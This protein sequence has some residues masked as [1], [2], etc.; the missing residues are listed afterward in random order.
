MFVHVVDFF[1]AFQ[2]QQVLQTSLI[3]DVTSPVPGQMTVQ[4]CRTSG[5]ITQ[6]LSS[7]SSSCMIML[8][9]WSYKC[10]NSWSSL[11]RL[12]AKTNFCAM[13]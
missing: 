10:D 3:L 7:N 12:Q 4:S 1:N 5:V 11:A 13:G 9:P 8:A 6:V 2:T